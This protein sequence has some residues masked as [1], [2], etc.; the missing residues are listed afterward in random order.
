MTSLL[1]KVATAVEA[2]ASIVGA[3]LTKVWNAAV[4]EATTLYTNDVKP[5]VQA[6]LTYIENNGAADLLLIGQRVVAA[7]VADL[8]DPAT[9]YANLVALA[10]TVWDEAKSAGL[11]IEQG[12]ALLV[13]TMAH[14]ALTAPA[15]VAAPAAETAPV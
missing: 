4:A 11:A 2:D 15:V 5:I 3:D 1:Q 7:G 13:T 14:A 9:L 8:A 12:A 10:G 6:T